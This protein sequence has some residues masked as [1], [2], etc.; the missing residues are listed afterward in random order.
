MHIRF[1]RNKKTDIRMS[2]NFKIMLKPLNAHMYLPSPCSRQGAV[3][4]CIINFYVVPCIFLK[5]NSQV[6]QE[7][8]LAHH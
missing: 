5:M 1:T 4:H 7:R 8:K 6:E 2:L 3:C